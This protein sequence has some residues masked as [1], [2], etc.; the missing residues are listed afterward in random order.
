MDFTC[1][2]CSVSQGN[3]HRLGIIALLHDMKAGTSTSH[4]IP[5]RSSYIVNIFLAF[6]INILLLLT[7][8]VHIFHTYISFTGQRKFIISLLHLFLIFCAPS[9]IQEHVIQLLLLKKLRKKSFPFFNTYC[10]ANC[11]SSLLLRS[12]SHRQYLTID[13]PSGF[14]SGDASQNLFSRL[15]FFQQS[16]SSQKQKIYYAWSSKLISTASLSVHCQCFNVVK[17]AFASDGGRLLDFKLKISFNDRS[18]I[19][20]LYSKICNSLY[21]SASSNQFSIWINQINLAL[22]TQEKKIRLGRPIWHGPLIIN[23]RKL[24]EWIVNRS[25]FFFFF[26]F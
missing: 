1:V 18:I 16:S 25:G 4:W 8:N 11:Q 2:Q 10:S 13:H 12:D 6:N 20:S 3:S 26:F 22:L 7:Y 9:C 5:A 24:L 14:Y 21:K 19:Q 17:L 15:Y 23:R